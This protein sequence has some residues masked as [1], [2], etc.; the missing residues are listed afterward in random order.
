MSTSGKRG[1]RAP[2]SAPAAPSPAA[3]PN[4]PPTDDQQVQ[5]Q[6]RIMRDSGSSWDSKQLN[7]YRINHGR[8]STQRPNFRVL[9]LQQNVAKLREDIQQQIESLGFLKLTR[10]PHMDLMFPPGT[11]GTPLGPFFIA[12]A[13]VKEMPHEPQDPDNTRPKRER[14]QIQRE[15]MV[16]STVAIKPAGGIEA[17]DNEIEKRQSRRMS[18]RSYSASSSD[19]YTESKHMRRIKPETTTQTMFYLFCQ[20]IFEGSN[21]GTRAPESTISGRDQHR[22]EWHVAG[23]RFDIHSP[24]VKCATINDGNLFWKGFDH[25]GQWGTTAHPLAYCSIEVSIALHGV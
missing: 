18:N 9:F 12:L 11:S 2:A 7:Y 16:D 13:T 25:N 5:P 8:I 24:M 15:G 20:A 22:L 19:A 10:S 1:K 21:L 3:A 4:P 17:N 6:Y 23:R 14:K